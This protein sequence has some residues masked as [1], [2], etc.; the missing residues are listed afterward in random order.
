MR[1]W[2]LF[3]GWMS[4]EPDLMREGGAG[5]EL[6]GL[7]KWGPLLQEEYKKEYFLRLAERVDTAYSRGDP[8]VFPPREA[9]FRAF[10]RT[11]PERV[12]AVILGQDPYPTKAHADGLAF[13]ARE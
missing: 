6:E 1:A 4:D 3:C 8:R 12:R 11:P 2:G 9:L 10:S 7:G 13:S 5:M